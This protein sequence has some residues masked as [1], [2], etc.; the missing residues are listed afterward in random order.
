MNWRGRPL[1]DIRTIVE[2]ISATTTRSGLTVQ[3]AYDP[4]WYPTGGKISDNDFARIPLQPHS[5]HGE[6]NYV[7]TAG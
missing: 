1:T 7:I 2:L 3:A 5:F 4:S 6:W